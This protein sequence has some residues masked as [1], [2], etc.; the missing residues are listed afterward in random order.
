MPHQR[1]LFP[2]S[3]PLYSQG[4]PL[5]QRLCALT[6]VAWAVRV[7]LHLSV[8]YSVT[9]GYSRPGAPLFP[10]VVHGGYCYMGIASDPGVAVEEAD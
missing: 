6:P 10:P 7:Y 3:V 1:L 2:L 4:L 8:P 9:R 5:Q